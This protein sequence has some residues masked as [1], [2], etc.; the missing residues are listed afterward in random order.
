MYQLPVKPTWDLFA[1]VSH[2]LGSL[3]TVSYKV[4][5]DAA[6]SSITHPV[7]KTKGQMRD[8]EATQPT[9][10]TMDSAV[11]GLDSLKKIGVLV[12]KQCI[13]IKWILP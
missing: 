5:C 4:D 7:S 13:K 9:E 10:H 11:Y 12:K 8:P 6:R 1:H 3:R 2:K